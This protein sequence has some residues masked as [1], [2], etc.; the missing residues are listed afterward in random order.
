M[1]H[2]KIT[3]EAFKRLRLKAGHTQ[4]EAAVRVGVSV[5]QLQRWESGEQSIAYAY[6]FLYNSMVAT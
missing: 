3:A 1:T 5:R 6:Y 2:P 4:K